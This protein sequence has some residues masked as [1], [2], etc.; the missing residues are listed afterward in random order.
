M[1]KVSAFIKVTLALAETFF[2]AF[3]LP[4]SFSFSHMNTHIA[5]ESLSGFFLLHSFTLSFSLSVSISLSPFFPPIPSSTP[6][7][8]HAKEVSLYTSQELRE[9][10]AAIIGLLSNPQTNIRHKEQDQYGML[11]SFQVVRSNQNASCE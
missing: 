5:A 8:L 11:A 4:L 2:S 3:S 9:S 6:P 7:F 1:H 10:C